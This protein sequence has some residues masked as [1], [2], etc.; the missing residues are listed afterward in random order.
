MVI[1]FLDSYGNTQENSGTRTQSLSRS[2][3]SP[4]IMRVPFFLLFGF[5]KGPQNEKCKRVLLRNLE[6]DVEVFIPE[7]PLTQT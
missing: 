7:R 3:S 2:L 5:N 4:F 1:S 6:I